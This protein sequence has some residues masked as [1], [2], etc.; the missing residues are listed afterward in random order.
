MDT[1]MV[2]LGLAAI[3]TVGTLGVVAIVYGR[4]FTTKVR[5]DELNVEVGADAE[6]PGTGESE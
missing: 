5:K 6:I 2:A 4:R 1:G 3:V